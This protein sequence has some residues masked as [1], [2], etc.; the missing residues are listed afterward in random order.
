MVFLLTAG[1]LGYLAGKGKA[2]MNWHVNIARITIILGL[3]HGLA[4]ILVV[5][6]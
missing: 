2:K 6:R 4:V 1:V 5:M 3:L